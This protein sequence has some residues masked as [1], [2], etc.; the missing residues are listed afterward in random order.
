MRNVLEWVVERVADWVIA[1]LDIGVKP[2][3]RQIDTWTPCGK[4]DPL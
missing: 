1:G 4:E 2:P 3:P